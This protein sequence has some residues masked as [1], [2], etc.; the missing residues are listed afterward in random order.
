MAEISIMYFLQLA[1]RRIWILII[2]AVLC[3]GV[4]LGYCQFIA[5]PRYQARASII[6]TNGA[7]FVDA[8][9][10]EISRVDSVSGSDISS[11]L[12]LSDTVIDILKTPDIYKQLKEKNSY[13][14]KYNHGALMGMTSIAKRSGDS[15]FI[16]LYFTNTDPKKAVSLVNDFAEMSCDYIMEYIPYSSAKVGAKAEGASKTFP[17]NFKTVGIAA[18]IG[19]A[20]A[21]LAVYL[22][23]L[24]D[25]AIKGEEDF[26]THYE[27]PLIGVIPDFENGIILKSDYNYKNRWYASNVK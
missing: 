7:I 1:V 23:D 5:T 3:A 20:L 8:Y 22:I 15:L 26:V 13:A 17:N 2:T 6:V 21:Y 27:I 24:M 19:V 14:A 25:K 9:S 11:S 16:D 12:S 10:K 18:L 4:A